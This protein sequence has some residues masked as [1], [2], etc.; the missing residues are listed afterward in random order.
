M[1]SDYISELASDEIARRMARKLSE[2]E[3]Q[4]IKSCISEL[5]DLGMVTNRVMWFYNTVYFMILRLFITAKGNK[6]KQLVEA[7]LNELNNSSLKP[8]VK[9]CINEFQGKINYKPM[10]RPI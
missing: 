7:G 2:A 9:P 10:S 1:A 5:G 6:F 3:S 8:E 4:N